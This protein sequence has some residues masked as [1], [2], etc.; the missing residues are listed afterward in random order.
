ML[1]FAPD[2]ANSTLQNKLL[3]LLTNKKFVLCVSLQ[4]DSKRHAYNRLIISYNATN[5]IKTPHKS[6]KTLCF[7]TSKLYIYDRR[8]NKLMSLLV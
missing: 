2:F 8:T 4:R 7:L 3:G 5:L 1:T 6:A